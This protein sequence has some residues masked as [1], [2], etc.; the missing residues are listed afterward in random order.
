MTPFIKMNGSGNDFVIF[1]ARH[2][3]MNLTVDQ[4]R[5]IADRKNTTTEGC[6][7][8]IVMEPSNDADVFMRI[9]NADG[10]EINACGNATRCVVALM[11]KE[12]NKMPITVQ[13][14]AGILKGVEKASIEGRELILVDMG[15]PRL[16]WQEIPL[17]M[18]FEDAIE[19][20][21]E[22]SKP[23]G[24][25]GEP[26]FVNMG[27]PHVIFFQEFLAKDYI[28]NPS[29]VVGADITEFG[30]ALENY[31]DVFPDRV[32]VSVASLYLEQYGEGASGHRIIAQVWERGAGL[33]K[34]CGTAACAMLVAANQV[35]PTI[36][37]ATVEFVNSDEDVNVLIDNDGHVLLGGLIEEEFRANVDL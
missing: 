10:S 11:E 37:K 9:Y 1:D 7:Q 8:V 34:A 2:Q 18:P 33:T 19:K 27:N 12:L 20:I 15:T 3:S 31:K 16:T 6:D 28:A 26:L 14:N 25:P 17:S 13:T 30:H 21:D 23:Y 29:L 36:R 22:F 5:A 24:D 32:N 35:D 4:V